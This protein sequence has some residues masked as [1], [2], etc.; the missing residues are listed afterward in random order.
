[1]QADPLGI[2]LLV[3]TFFFLIAVS[4]SCGLC[5]WNS[6]RVDGLVSWT[7]LDDCGAANGKRVELL[8]FNGD[9]VFLF[10]PVN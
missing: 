10:W 9:S 6:G 8:F 3:G 4:G 1:M 5:A 7:S 2:T